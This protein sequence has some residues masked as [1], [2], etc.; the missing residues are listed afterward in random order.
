MSNKR[1]DVYIEN[2][3]LDLFDDEM[4]NIKR[5]V[6]D[7]RDISKVFTDLSIPFTVPASQNNNSIFKHFYNINI[8]GGFDARTRKDARVEIGTLPFLD[9]KAKLEE[10]LTRNG[11]PISYKLT[12]FGILVNLTD[13]FKEDYLDV[14]DLSAFDHVY[15]YTNVKDGLTT[16]LFSGSVIYSM[17]SPVRRW[18]YDS[19]TSEDINTDTMVNIAYDAGTNRGIRFTELKPSLLV[20]DIIDAVQ[21]YYNIT[22]PTGIF[23]SDA[24][25]G[26]YMLAHRESGY[27]S[28]EFQ[29]GEQLIDWQNGS[30]EYVNFDTDNLAVTTVRNSFLVN[31]GLRYEFE[32]TI[33]PSSGYMTVPYDLFVRD[34]EQGNQIVHLY[35]GI[36]GINIRAENVPE[37]PFVGTQDY[38]YT[39]YVRSEQEF[40]YTASL[41]VTKIVNGFI[42]NSETCSNNEQTSTSQIIFS[43][44][45]PQ[46]KVK[47]FISGLVKMYNSTITP[48]DQNT[49]TFETLDTWYAQGDI[50]D[51]SQFIRREKEVSVKKANIFNRIKFN[52]QEPQTLLAIQFKTTNNIAYGDLEVDL[53]DDSGE[54]LEG[55]EFEVELPFENMIYERIVD[56][57][58]SI[59]T[60]L[61]YGYI[62]DNSESP[63]GM[64]PHIHYGI[65]RNIGTKTFALLDENDDT[66]EI[67]GNVWMPSHTNDTDT[68]DYSTN[69]GLEL[70]EYDSQQ[71]ANSLYQIY[72]NDYI[73]DVFDIKRRLLNYE[74]IPTEQILRNLKLNDRLIIDGN[75]FIINDMNVGLTDGTIKAQLL[76][77][78]FED[79]SDILR[80]RVSAQG[81]IVEHEVITTGFWTATDKFDWIDPDPKTGTGTQTIDIIVDPNPGA[82]EREGSVSISTVED[83]YLVYIVQ[84]GRDITFDRTDITFDSDTITF[85]RT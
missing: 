24:F 17:F 2:Q 9:M 39:F 71:I 1:V 7:V 34:A 30:Q 37:P 82:E 4:I 14:I 59:L 67:T 36:T 27:L 54:L 62:V 63:T 57:D 21:A 31:S 38:D 69:W 77:D 8:D 33:T 40:K 44:L 42:E 23:D 26:L 13:I 12:L 84:N 79:L 58:D 61:M 78:I 74:L 76:N 6:Q 32:I 15:N 25:N 70:D 56:L 10:V 35:S 60:E 80:I 51:V 66:E 65:S 53:F 45:L 20:T 46:I 49:F 81:G 85:D 28:E 18:I 72:Y 48:N 47:D 68:K 41:T 22:F 43:T 52:F 55:T 75:R 19:D 64:E 50:I 29:I 16:G 83:D 11:R 5:K 3:R 73:T